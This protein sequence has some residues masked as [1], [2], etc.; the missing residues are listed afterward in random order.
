MN[1]FRLSRADAASKDF[2]TIQETHLERLSS[3][4]RANTE[5]RKKEEKKKTPKKKKRS[6]SLCSTKAKSLYKKAPKFMQSVQ[7]SM[8]TSLSRHYK[9]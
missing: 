4:T 1:T 7:F 9:V 2:T 6:H 5:K 3:I 8:S